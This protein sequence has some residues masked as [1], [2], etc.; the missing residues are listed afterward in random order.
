MFLSFQTILIINLNEMRQPAAERK[1]VLSM[2][3]AKTFT[4]NREIQFLFQVPS[5]MKD[6]STSMLKHE[7][8][9]TQSPER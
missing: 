2:A 9:W 5:G 1:Y 6:Q 7:T 4:Q 3:C 8:D